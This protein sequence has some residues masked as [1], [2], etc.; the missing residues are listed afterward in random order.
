M[1]K[2][3]GEGWDG[4][5]V[6]KWVGA[7]EIP[8]DRRRRIG[9]EKLVGLDRVT[10]PFGALNNKS[11]FNEDSGGG[12][13]GSSD[14]SEDR[15]CGG[16]LIQISDFFPSFFW[17]FPPCGWGSSLVSGFNYNLLAILSNGFMMEKWRSIQ[18]S[19]EEEEGV[20]VAE[21]EVGEEE[22]FQR[23]LAGKLWTD[24]SFNVR[25]FK[26][27]M[28]SAWKLKNQ[29][30]TQDL[31]KNLFLFKFAT[32]RDLDFVIKNGPWS[33]DRLLLVL[34]RIS[35]EEKPSDI[36]MH[37]ASFWVRIYELPL[38]LRSEA[39]AK[40]IG[41]TLGNFEEMD[42]REVCRNGR[43]LRIKVILDLKLPLKGETVIKF[44][45]KNLRVHFKYERLPIFCFVCGRLG[46]QMKDCEAVEDLSEEGCEELEEKDL[47]YGQWLRASP[48]PKM[49]EEQKK[50]DSSSGT[51]SK[52]LF[53]VSS[54]QSRCE[55][56]IQGTGEEPEVQ[57]AKTTGENPV[58]IGGSKNPEMDK[59]KTLEIERVAESF[60]AVAF[61][62]KETGEEMGL[63]NLQNTRKNLRKWGEEKETGFKCRSSKFTATR[64]G[65]GEPTP[66]IPMKAISW[67][68]R[69]LGHRRAVRALMRLIRLEKP[70]LVFLMETRLKSDEMQRIGSK[71][72]FN[73]IFSI[74]CRGSGRG[75][76][77]G[78]C[79][80]WVEELN[81][82]I[83]SH[84]PNHI[85]GLCR[86]GEEDNPWALVG[87]YGF[88]EE[89]LKR[90]TW[91]LV[92]KVCNDLGELLI[93]FGDFNDILLDIEKVG[94][95]CRT[96]SQL[97]WGRKAIEQSGLT[98]VGFM[99][100]P[101]TWSNGRQGEENIQCRLDRSFVSQSFKE[102]FP[103]TKV[104]HLPRHGSD[105]AAL[106]ISI[107]K[108]GDREE[109]FYL[110]RFEEVWSKDPRCEDL[111]KQIW[112]CGDNTFTHK[113]KGMQ[114][115]STLLKEYRSG[116]VAKEIRRLEY[117]LKEK[118]RWAADPKEIQNF[119]NLEKQRGKLLGIEETIWRQRSRAMWL[120]DGDRNTKFFHSKAN[121]RRKTNA[122][123]RLKD[124]NVNWFSGSRHCERILVDY[125]LEIFKSSN[126]KGIDEVCSFV[127]AKISENFF[128]VCASPFSELDVREVI[129]QMHPTK[130][131]GSNGLPALFFQK[132]WNIVGSD[133]TA[134]ALD[135]LNNQ[136]DPSAIN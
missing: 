24:S 43:F 8:S 119:K 69:G 133:V 16:S 35:G 10:A 123:K 51:C 60:G 81:I 131:P 128:Y 77:G 134:V 101:F 59:Q 6:K 120:K 50:R 124:R 94:E 70:H 83:V 62:I 33:F 55:Q 129:F 17:F 23:T 98:D 46:H 49:G 63:K 82:Q 13:G 127:N 25:A 67:N 9:G 111:V 80:L 28:I 11:E 85:G 4:D 103:N 117:L 76:V 54:G 135:I 97:S 72:G 2:I 32:K 48:L 126:P 45:E 113:T 56:K 100:Y 93:M 18:L 130:S 15:F 96:L 132:Y 112:R 34:N 87:I 40:K 26:S 53:N 99:G 118:K 90:H 19:K 105:H 47:S 1:M 64:G 20:V 114:E 79:L 108:E 3:D 39:M 107:E 31:G 42:L 91:Q 116:S 5:E 66:P 21:E 74:D 30:E 121:Q 109:R 57:Q 68:C 12:G 115:L 58:E 22:L 95:N 75:R 106:H 136:R 86:E 29:V 125:F 38:K 89:H 78:L 84:S 36:N 7:E 61:S 71:V 104:T 52:S 65:V 44:K 122:I 110:F 37:F 92:Q 73:N 14:G 27:T 88:P 41:S 102:Q